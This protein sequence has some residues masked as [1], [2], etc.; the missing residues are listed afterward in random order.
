MKFA[1]G[2]NCIMAALL[3]AAGIAAALTPA[4]ARPAASSS[5]AGRVPAQQTESGEKKLSL[6][7]KERQTVLL[8]AQNG[9]FEIP[10]EPNAG[11]YRVTDPGDGRWVKVQLAEDGSVLRAKSYLDQ[12]LTADEPQPGDT[13]QAQT[14]EETTQ[15][16][17]QEPQGTT[18][19]PDAEEETTASQE[20]KKDEMPAVR[21]DG[22]SFTVVCTDA[23]GTEKEASFVLA[24]SA[25]YTLQG[26]VLLEKEQYL[27]AKEVRIPFTVGQED[28]VLHCNNAPFPAGTVYEENGERF[29]LYTAQPLRVGAGSTVLLDFS[30]TSVETAL[31]FTGAEQSYTLG[32]YPMPCFST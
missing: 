28:A 25:E 16:A 27:Y 20:E 21:P 3:L 23:D 8:G 24:A 26:T 6:F 29:V 5:W 9:E 12:M 10:L 30:K 18:A 32:Y 17:T 1:K 7:E 13:T 2:A 19:E 4:L 11:E 31:F 15:P 22:I 14:T